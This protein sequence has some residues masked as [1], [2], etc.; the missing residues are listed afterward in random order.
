M[1]ATAELLAWEIGNGAGLL[2]GEGEGHAGQES[3]DG[4]ELVHVEAEVFGEA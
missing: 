4:D 2:S 3:S 1:A